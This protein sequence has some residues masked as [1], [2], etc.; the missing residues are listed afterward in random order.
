MDFV[1][2]VVLCAIVFIAVYAL[3]SLYEYRHPPVPA[4]LKLLPVDQREQL[5]PHEE[6]FFSRW[7]DPEACKDFFDAVKVFVG[8]D[9]G[10]SPEKR[11]YPQ[12]VKAQR[13]ARGAEVTLQMPV[14]I[15]ADDVQ[16]AVSRG[17]QWMS[18]DGVEDVAVEQASPG[19]VVVRAVTRD[20]FE[21]N[22]GGDFL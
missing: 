19:R 10:D 15:A 4:G 1:S 6:E 17:G 11:E 18:I 12:P 21:S 8:D 7:G 14:G 9:D 3:M 22:L 13:T 20:A 16:K 5:R 2:L